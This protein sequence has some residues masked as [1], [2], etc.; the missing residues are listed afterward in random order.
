MESKNI[1]VVGNELN[2]FS[3][4]SDM[5]VKVGAIKLSKKDLN[6]KLV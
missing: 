5:L 1:S 6:Q 3:N 4:K 2:I